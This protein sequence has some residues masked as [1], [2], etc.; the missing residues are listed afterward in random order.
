[1]RVGLDLS[2]LSHPHPP[3]VARVVRELSRR[4]LASERFEF[5]ELK[6]AAGADLRVWRQQELPRSIERDGLAGIHSFVSAFPWRGGG[7]ITSG[8]RDSP[9]RFCPGRVDIG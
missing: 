1:M 6:P 3:G 2:P 9:Q 8:S 7:T 4:L 5:V